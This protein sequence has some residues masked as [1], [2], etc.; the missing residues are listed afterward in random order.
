MKIVSKTKKKLVF[1]TGKTISL[2]E[3]RGVSYTIIRDGL[4]SDK[5]SFDDLRIGDSVLCWV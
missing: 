4:R 2:T 3:A 1:G 5:V